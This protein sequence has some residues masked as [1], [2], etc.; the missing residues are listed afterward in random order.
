MALIAATV[1]SVIDENAT[2]VH[3]EATVATQRR[4]LLLHVQTLHLDQVL[5][6][7]AAWI[8]VVTSLILTLDL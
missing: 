7:L 1:V 8:V 4:L 2:H 5:H 6:V 3:S